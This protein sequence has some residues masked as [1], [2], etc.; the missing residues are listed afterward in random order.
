MLKSGDVC[1][2]SES[3]GLADTKPKSGFRLVTEL[4]S[5]IPKETFDFRFV[6]SK[7]IDPV[8]SE[9]QQGLLLLKTKRGL[10]KK[11]PL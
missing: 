2:R 7:L 11:S 5:K 3:V 10:L 8:V 1:L 6:Y 4:K 9:S